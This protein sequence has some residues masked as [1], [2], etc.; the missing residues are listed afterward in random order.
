MPDETAPTILPADEQGKQAPNPD[1]AVQTAAATAQRADAERLAGIEKKLAAMADTV[2]AALT[3]RYTAQ[4]SEHAR[5]GDIPAHFRNLL[6][7]QGLTDAD[8]DA[9]AP[10]VVPFLSAM[11]ATDGAVIASGIQ[12]VKDEVEMVKAAR[13]TK[14]FPYWGDLEEKILE[15][16]EDAAKNGQYLSP[17]DAYRAAVAVDVAAGNDSR[18]EKART[19]ARADRESS[20]ADVTA[21]N[22]GTHHGQRP[23]QATVR[24]TALTAEDIAALPR[25]ERKKL[26]AEQLGDMPIR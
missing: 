7:Q 9:N 13:S 6:R 21:Q 24:R 14:K 4:P 20:A 11:L 3:P 5:P 16:R 2:Q 17:A 10:I 26:F 18:I 22:L 19:R 1:A 25:E 23:G 12:Q 15:M 8:I